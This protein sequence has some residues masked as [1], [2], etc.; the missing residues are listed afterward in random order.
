MTRRFNTAGPCKPDL[1]YMLPPLRRLPDLRPLI[2]GQ[3]AFVIHAP[4]QTGKTTAIRQLASDL[5][6]EGRFAS[7]VL[8]MEVGEPF[9]D[10][11]EAELAV[12]SDWSSEAAQQLPEVL[13]PPAWPLAAA[14][15]RLLTALRHWA[16]TC[17]LPIVLLLD[18][19]DSLQPRVLSSLLRQ[20]RSGFPGRPGGFPWSLALV[21]MRDV[22][23]Y[24]LA[25]GGTGRHGRVSPFNVSSGSIT[26]RAFTRDE[27]GEL[28]AQHA[29]E[30]GQAFTGDAVDR[31]Y[32]LTLGQ[33]WLVNAL[34]RECVEVLLPGGQSVDARHIDAARDELVRRLDTHLDSLGERLQEPR[35]QAV[36]E[37]L[38][39]GEVLG[40]I[41]GDDQRYALELGLVRL[42]G[43]GSLRLANPI[44][45]E[46][47]PRALTD[48]VSNK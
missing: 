17:P 32:E 8:S 44:Y 24:V 37:P 11:G 40:P 12:L 14:G 35:V 46:V 1:H 47:V 43:D 41:Q 23:D 38:L 29:T 39:A 20:L 5:T 2:E 22:R 42:D 26:L 21:G 7:V 28:Y 9:E 45:E 16:A 33:P 18:E 34:A 4:R 13:R 10:P 30:Q 48:R 27:V 36:V 25:S 19:V 3:S 15:A 31:A 6:G